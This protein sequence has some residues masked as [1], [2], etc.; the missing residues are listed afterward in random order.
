MKKQSLDILY[1]HR[2]HLLEREQIVLQD[3]IAEENQQKIRLL[4]LQARVQ[5]THNAKSRATTAE[6]L[7][8]LDESAAYLHG[9]MT[10]ARRALM[11]S[12]QAREEALTRTLKLK[13]ERDQVGLML[14][15]KRLER[16]RQ[17]DESEKRQS[18]ELVTARYAMALGGL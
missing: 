18:D 1:R 5:E 14:E 8:T 10:L 16:L 11:I 15:K 13:Q 4:Q 12:S 6:E 2:T 3:K 9:R 7:S 17:F